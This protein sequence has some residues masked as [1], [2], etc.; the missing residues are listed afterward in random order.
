MDSAPQAAES[1][2]LERRKFAALTHLM[3]PLA[4]HLA[5]DVTEVCINKPGE[6]WTEGRDGWQV[7]TDA[8]LTFNYLMQLARVA[9]TAAGQNIDAESPILSTALPTGERIQVV[10]PPVTAPN[11]VSF[12]IRKP[13]SVRF[14]MADY[15]ATGFFDH[16]QLDNGQLQEHET[17]LQ[18]LLAARKLGAFF[19]LAVTSR[20]TILVSG[21]TGSGKTTFMKALV[22]LIPSSERLVTIEDAPE[23][24]L[25]KHPNHVR[26]FYSKGGQGIAAVGAKE[27]LESN[28]RMK[29]DRI[30][31]AEVRDSSAFHF[32]S[33]ANSGHPG[34]ITSIH[35]NGPKEAFGRLA[36]LMGSSPDAAGMSRTDLMNLIL[37]TIDIVVQVGRTGNLRAATG[38]YYAPE[39]KLALMG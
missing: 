34:S 37:S 26:L 3:Q 20:Q 30:L 24:D 11:T 4:A 19:E 18:D 12:T 5:G 16:I 7:H 15:Q 25:P 23:L 29:P 33:G 21:G 10:M 31:Q 9:G 2:E 22:D 6:F 38:I 28:M 14:N 32:V 36:I 39:R 27:C 13:S 35:A 1:A 8:A 17:Q